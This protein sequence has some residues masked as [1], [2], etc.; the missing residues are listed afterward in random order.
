MP[1]SATSAPPRTFPDCWGHRGASSRFPENTLASFEA[2][3]R[4]GAEGIESDVHVSADDVVIMFHDPALDR[5]TDSA[6]KIRDKMWHGADGMQHVRTKKEPKQTIPT[7]AQTVEL[8]MRPENRHVKFNV[9][10]KAENDPDKLFQLMHAVIAAQADFE[11][12]LAPRILLGLWHPRFIAPAKA[13]LPYCRR[14]YIGDSTYIAR[15]YFW[16]DCH[17]FSM[18]FGALTTADGQKFRAECKKQGKNLMVWTV[19]QP[20]HM[21]EAVRWEVNAIIT[22]VTKTWL[23][24]RSALQTDYDKIGSQYGRSFLWTTLHFY[25]PFLFLAK[26][27]SLKDLESKAGPFDY[28]ASLVETKA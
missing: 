25:T 23:D 4:D 8:L 14:S 26:R 1:V 18:S 3:M 5:V 6:G 12:V 10:V 19:N 13:R 21:M 17:A 11:T 27:E 20:D 9:D 24:L 22:D 15:K 7:F 16:K 2:A 28:V